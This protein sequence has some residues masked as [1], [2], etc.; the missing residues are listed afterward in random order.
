MASRVTHAKNNIEALHQKG[1][2]RDGENTVRTTLSEP[3]VSCGLRGQRHH[4]SGS[5]GE[6]HFVVLCRIVY[7]LNIDR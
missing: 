6:P 5:K 7:C 1:A 2:A 4:K 3:A